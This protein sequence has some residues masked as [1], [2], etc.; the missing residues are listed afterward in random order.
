[1]PQSVE[2]SSKDTINLLLVRVWALGFTGSGGGNTGISL[3]DYMRIII[4]LVDPLP[5][6]RYVAVREGSFEK[7]K[8]SVG[9]HVSYSLNSQCSP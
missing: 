2:R 6:P 4:S 8:P 1:M 5:T 7:E 3:A 9:I